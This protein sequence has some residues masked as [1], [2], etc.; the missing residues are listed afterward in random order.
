MS[1]SKNSRKVLHS[2]ATERP[3]TKKGT[4]IKMTGQTSNG[5]Y[6]S[7]GNAAPTNGGFGIGRA[8]TAGNINGG[9]IDSL[10]VTGAGAVGGG[11]R[12]KYTKQNFDESEDISTN[13]DLSQRPPSRHKDPTLMS[14]KEF[15]EST[16]PKRRQKGTMEDPMI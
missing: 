16:F 8:A 5:V 1:S 14:G 3:K 2:N 15:L 7:M 11:Q 12:R 13:V 10:M 9:T 4:R 6:G